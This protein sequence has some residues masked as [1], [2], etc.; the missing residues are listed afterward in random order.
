[1]LLDMMKPKVTKQNHRFWICNR[2][3]CFQNELIIYA[4][5]YSQNKFKLPDVV[6]FHSKESK[7]MVLGTTS[8]RASTV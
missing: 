3:F 2:G 5:K 8:N 4:R 6:Q 7:I 1:M